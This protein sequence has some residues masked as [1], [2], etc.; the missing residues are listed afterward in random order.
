MPGD[1]KHNINISKGI[2]F[3]LLGSK[4]PQALTALIIT[5]L[6]KLILVRKKLF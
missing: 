4:I 1:E 6:F 5:V 2:F 3:M